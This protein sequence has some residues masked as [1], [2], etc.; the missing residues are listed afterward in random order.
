MLARLQLHSLIN[1]TCVLVIGVTVGD[2]E[3][4]VVWVRGWNKESH[5]IT[6]SG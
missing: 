6:I 4:L 2:M 5:L 1:I 3:L